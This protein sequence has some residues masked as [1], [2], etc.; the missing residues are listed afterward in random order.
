MKKLFFIFIFL[1]SFVSLSFSDYVP[2]VNGT[3]KFMTDK[4]EVITFMVVTNSLKMVTEDGLV[5]NLNLSF[6]KEDYF[7]F[8]KKDNGEAIVLVFDNY[9]MAILQ[10]SNTYFLYNAN[11]KAI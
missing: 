8:G 1:I 2:M 9:C 3:H 11:C 7:Y 6:D 5:T 4:G 10:M